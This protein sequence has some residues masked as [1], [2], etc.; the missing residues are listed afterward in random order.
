M[1]HTSLQSQTQTFTPTTPQTTKC[2]LTMLAVGKKKK[3]EKDVVIP[4]TRKRLSPPVTMDIRGVRVHFP[5]TPYKVQKDY[6]TTIMDSLL[7]GQHALLESPT[8]TG[9]TLCLLCAT[10]AWQRQIVLANNDSSSQKPPQKIPTIVYASR[11][12]SQLSQVLRELRN[13]RYRP[14]HTLLASREQM[15]IHPK[16]KKSSS[17]NADCQA[18]GK[19]RRC[20]YRNRLDGFEGVSPTSVLDLEELVEMGQK[21]KVCP[22]FYSKSQ[23][24]NAELLLMP[25]NYLLDP[26]VRLE[27]DLP[28]T[29]VILDEAHNLESFCSDSASFDI[30]MVHLAGC[31]AECDKVLQLPDAVGVNKNNVLTLKAMCLQMQEHLHKLPVP[32]SLK[33]DYIFEFLQTA[34]KINH[35]NYQLFL[36]E[37][38]KV[39][40]A[41]LDFSGA[42]RLEFLA[43]CV[44]RVLDGGTPS[45]AL[46]RAQHFR[47]YL[48]KEHTLSFWCFAPSV[49]M[50][51]LATVRSILVT[52]GTL[53]PLPSYRLELGLQIGHELENPHIIEKSQ[54]HVRVVGK[55]VAG[56][57]LCSSYE[58]RSQADYAAELGNTLVALAR[59]VPAGMLVFFPSYGVMQTCLQGW[60]AQVMNNSSQRGSFQAKKK[61]SKAQQF[62]FPRCNISTG[63]TPWKRLLATKAVVLE[64]R[65]SADLPSAMQ[66]FQK[67][68]T[69]PKSS[70]CV[71]MGVCRG[72]ISEGIDL[73]HDQSRAV[74][75]TGLPFPPA[76]DPKIKMKREYLDQARIARPATGAGGFG[77]SNNPAKEKLS[78][79]EWYAQ[80]AHRAVNQAIGR[81]IRNRADYGAVLLLDNRFDQPRNQQGL[82]KWVRPHVQKDEGFGQTIRSL[83]QFYKGALKHV[84]EQKRK[85]QVAAPIVQEDEEE[86]LTTTK[87]AVIKGKGRTNSSGYVPPEKVIAR[88][89][90]N[91]MEKDKPK[92]MPAKKP[93]PSHAA[94]FTANTEQPSVSKQLASQFMFKIKALPASDQTTMRKGVVQLKKTGDQNDIRAYLETACRLLA[95]IINHEGF[96]PV[97]FGQGNCLL[98]IF[99][100][101]LPTRHRDHV[102]DVAMNMV[103][104]KSAFGKACRQ[105]SAPTEFTR[106]QKAMQRLLGW[107]WCK[108]GGERTNRDFLDRAKDV[109]TLSSEPFAAFI[110]LIPPKYEIQARILRDKLSESPE[111]TKEQ[112]KRKAP[113]SKNP[114]ATAAKRVPTASSLGHGGKPTSSIMRTI[115]NSKP[116]EAKSQSAKVDAIDSNVP[117]DMVCPICSNKPDKPM[118]ALCGHTACRNCWQQWFRKSKTCPTCRKPTDN[119]SLA[120]AV[121]ETNEKTA[122]KLLKMLK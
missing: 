115:E 6:M 66:D 87:I 46:A 17:L 111:E 21:T 12:H 49:A 72:K 3:E 107:L 95:I 48:S 25:Y 55:G 101:L 4:T 73:S 23:T 99:L 50:H 24:D 10:L 68:L 70:G 69:M 76:M 15:C 7:Q 22:Y 109:L 8:G 121:F 98:W 113:I 42:P 108:D 82:S 57:L 13:T 11:T 92:K 84:E 30:T 60:G 67:Y 38:R 116:F 41:L 100:R 114:Y 118:I 105:K 63:Q 78:G 16:L 35:S 58:R 53:S 27:L 32:Q 2:V 90:V 36:D 34:A 64:P 5:F 106:I 26:Q 103:F 104:T 79:H 43:Q 31:V 77:N 19:E 28:N 102:E 39:Q 86:L 62:S 37:I 65:S 14:R 94:V 89:D 110:R 83:T 112:R 71:L 85:E 47:C 80:Q 93:A 52:S 119:T 45:K 117:E 122:P 91:T 33:G 96:H 88:L 75:I 51:G 74:I 120:R 61:K 40:D 18:L 56:G 9:K 29:V 59:V 20:L 1:S 54:V 44:G 81:V 97:A